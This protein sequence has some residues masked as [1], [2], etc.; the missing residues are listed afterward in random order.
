MEQENDIIWCDG[1]SQSN[2]PPEYGIGYGSYRIGEFGEIVSLDFNKKMSSNAAE[3]MTAAFAISASQS[4]NIKIYSDSKTAVS[5]INRPDKRYKDW[6]SQGM[7]DAIHLLR[8]AV[9]GKKIKAFY[10]PRALIF[11]IFK[12]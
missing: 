7:K 6:I 10:K 11:K 4:F 2:I 3:I 5:W 9:R 8:I 1:G 12:H